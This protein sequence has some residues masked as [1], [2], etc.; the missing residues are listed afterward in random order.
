MTIVVPCTVGRGKAVHIT[1]KDSM[2]GSL[3]AETLCGAGTCTVGTR[4]HSRPD[5]APFGT[6]ITCTRCQKLLERPGLARHF[7]VGAARSHR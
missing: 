4:R 6:P 5:A 2:T 3:I 7:E 1:L